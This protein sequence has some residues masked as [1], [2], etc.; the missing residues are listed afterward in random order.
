MVLV[1]K[2]MKTFTGKRSMTLLVFL[3]GCMSKHGNITYFDTPVVNECV[4]AQVQEETITKIGPLTLSSESLMFHD[5][6]Y[7]CCPSSD[8]T[9]NAKK[10]PPVCKEAFWTKAKK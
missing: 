1:G 6:L 8:T 2:C 3:M 5:Q 9:D 7:Y 10:P 4:W